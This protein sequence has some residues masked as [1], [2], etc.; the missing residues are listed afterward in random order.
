VPPGEY[1]ADVRIADL[2]STNERR[3]PF[4]LRA[5]AFDTGRVAI[6]APV[7]LSN[8]S[9]AMR[10]QEAALELAGNG[11]SFRYAERTAILIPSTVEAGI[12]WRFRLTA[13]TLGEEDEPPQED[14]TVLDAV[15][16]PTSVLPP[17]APVGAEGVIERAVLATVPGGRGA[18]YR[19]DMPS[20]TLPVGLY[21]LT[22]TATAPQGADSVSMLVRVLWREMPVSLRDITRAVHW[23]RHILTEEQYDAMRDG[24]PREQEQAFRRYWREHDPTP[25]T[26]YNELMTEYFRRVD[27]ANERFSTIYNDDGALTDRGKI[28]ILYG[29]PDDISRTLNAEELLRETWT[30]RTLGKTFRFVDKNRDRNLKLVP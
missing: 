15:L 14:G 16:Q 24:S 20:D 29:E 6:G 5:V 12:E 28:L 23:M 25:A 11:A 9:A 13:M 7:I 4:R 2:Q 8:A 22:I 27:A 1:L 19:F 18:M 17:M 30:Y 10:G 26:P 3:L 21:R